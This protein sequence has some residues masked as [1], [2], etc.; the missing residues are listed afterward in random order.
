MILLKTVPSFKTRRLEFAIKPE[1]IATN[2]SVAVHK[3]ELYALIPTMD[4]YVDHKGYYLPLPPGTP[5]P[6]DRFALNTHYLV[7]INADWSVRTAAEVRQSTPDGAIVAFRGFESGR[8][9]EWRGSLW[10]TLCLSGTGGKPAAEFYLARISRI[11]GS[12]FEFEE[13]RRV[14][15][16]EHAEK[17][18]MPQV[19]GDELVLHYSLGTMIDM[20]GAKKEI[21]APKYENLHGGSQ[22]IPYLKGGLCIVHGYHHVPNT[23]RKTAWHH[24]VY[25]DNCGRPDSISEPFAIQQEGTLEVV[26]GLARMVE[27]GQLIISYGRESSAA[28]NRL[29]HQEMPWVATMNV[30]ELYGMKWET[31]K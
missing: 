3:G 17:N 12:V 11:A 30:G 16:G 15:A 2:A 4:H 22:V 10:A 20:Q 26:T 8:L 18:W 13:V 29:R 6:P 7:Q 9:F 21:A 23:Y 14:T 31:I 1:F 28:D 25:I 5:L 24:F 27:A 19:I